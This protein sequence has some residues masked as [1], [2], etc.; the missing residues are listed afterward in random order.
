MTFTIRPKSN[1]DAPWIDALMRERW[2]GE[3]V[4]TRGRVLTPSELRGF[5]AGTGGEPAGLVT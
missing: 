3:V 2:G 5:L 4:V 1:D